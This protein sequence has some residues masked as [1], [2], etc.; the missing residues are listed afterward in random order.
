MHRSG[1][2]AITGML[3]LLG[4]QLSKYLMPANSHNEAGYWE[5]IFV[6]QLLERL[7]RLG[8]SRWHD[9]RRLDLTV[10]P[11]DAL[12]E[13]TNAILDCVRADSV[14]VKIFALKDPRVCRAVP[15]F[16]D[17]FNICDLEPMGIIITRHPLA[18]AHSLAKR[19]G[20]PVDKALLLW[21]RHMLDAERNTRG[22]KR[23][24][25]G[26]QE[27]LD[28]W[29]SVAERIGVSLEIDWPISP[30]EARAEVDAFLR[31]SLRHWTADPS[32]FSEISGVP[33][34]LEAWE[35]LCLCCEDQ[36]RRDEQFDVISMQIEAG[37]RPFENYFGKIETRLEQITAAAS[38]TA[39]EL[40]RAKWLLGHSEVVNLMNRSDIL[41]KN[42]PIS[43]RLVSLEGRVEKL[44]GRFAGE[45]GLSPEK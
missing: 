14:G 36:Q 29:L 25:V 9:W 38:L 20:M 28:N 24:F 27:L 3:S 26:Y 13:I 15:L 10:I 41:A 12:A 22:M 34:F 17:V 18:V 32:L 42:N 33:W 30:I 7:L 39:D 4:V 40:D 31:P 2:S 44:E 1:T 45:T 35:L 23:V 11:P 6:N 16:I 37:M 5:S 8:N 19:D 21:A 43:N